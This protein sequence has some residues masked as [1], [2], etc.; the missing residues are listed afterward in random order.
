MFPSY[1]YFSSYWCGL[2]RSVSFGLFWSVWFEVHK[3]TWKGKLEIQKPNF[4]ITTMSWGK[5]EK[6]IL[7]IHFPWKKNL[8]FT[9]LIFFWWDEQQKFDELLVSD[10]SLVEEAD[11][12]WSCCWYFWGGSDV[13]VCSWTCHISVKEGMK[14]S[15]E[16]AQSGALSSVKW[17][18]QTLQGCLWDVTCQS[19][20]YSVVTSN[21]VLFKS[22]IEIQKHMNV[23]KKIW[24]FVWS[25]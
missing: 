7:D 5:A 17:R 12:L 24:T 19:A 11:V 21:Y 13:H 16:N 15:T 23:N 3:S 14:I 20:A 25:L 6:V 22:H 9:E 4:L 8:N 1:K 18:R 10:L 2:T